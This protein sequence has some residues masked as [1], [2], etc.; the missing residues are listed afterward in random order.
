M[1][2]VP[3]LPDRVRTFDDS[4]SISFLTS[5]FGKGPGGTTVIFTV[6]SRLEGNV[7]GKLFPEPCLYFNSRPVTGSE[8]LFPVR[9]KVVNRGPNVAECPNCGTE[10]RPEWSLCPHCKVNMRTFTG[11]PRGRVTR[12]PP[13]DLPAPPQSGSPPVLVPAP[14]LAAV[15]PGVPTSPVLA[16]PVQDGTVAPPGLATPEKAD[17][18]PRSCSRCG[19]P[20]VSPDSVY[21]MR[22]GH[23]IDRSPLIDRVQKTLSSPLVVGGL[24]ALF[25]LLLVGLVFAQGLGTPIPSGTEGGTGLASEAGGPLNAPPSTPTPTPEVSRPPVIEVPEVISLPTNVTQNAT[26]RPLE[27]VLLVRTLDRYIQD[28]GGDGDDLLATPSSSLTLL[29]TSSTPGSVIT[30]T[31]G[32]VGDHVWAGEGNYVTPSFVLDAGEVRLELVARELTMAQLLDA[33]RTVLGLV[34]AGPNTGGT[35]IRIPET[36]ACRIE[37]WPFGTGLWTVRVTQITPATPPI[38]PAPTGI[39]APVPSPTTPGTPGP[40][41][42]K[43]P[44]PVS[45]PFPQPPVNVTPNE[46]APPSPTQTLTPPPTQAPHTF[47]GNGSAV[48]PY[49]QLN[50]GVA[51]FRYS[52]LGDGPFTV[53][54]INGSGEVVDQ[55][56]QA[57]GTVSGS[58]AVGIPRLENH[59]LS[60]EAGGGWEISV[61]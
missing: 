37:V 15:V 31:P 24:T 42:S 58:K 2:P 38:A 5:G 9:C 52:Y 48:T 25:V 33:N 60:I 13:I 20:V 54:L 22:C 10:V 51:L 8:S 36:G 19:A 28:A 12:P 6:R 23:R 7:E 4:A 43:P 49:F 29:P 44:S 61:G 1:S 40:S 11:S 18:A 41:P 56:V 27:T 16:I 50:P 26:P 45:T 21:C 39:P 35:T 17:L 34:T 53:A 57:N 32:P 55:V 14:A 59:L 30:M 46:T 47:T 3:Y